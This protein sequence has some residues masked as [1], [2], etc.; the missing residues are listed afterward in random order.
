[1]STPR[2]TL[3]HKHPECPHDGFHNHAISRN[4]WMHIPQKQ[5]SRRFPFLFHE[6]LI[7]RCVVLRRLFVLDD[8]CEVMR[9]ARRINGRPKMSF[10]LGCITAALERASLLSTLCFCEFDFFDLTCCLAFGSYW[11]PRMVSLVF[12]LS[13][14]SRKKTILE[15]SNGM[16]IKFPTNTHGIVLF[17]D[18]RSQINWIYKNILAI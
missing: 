1:M 12:N 10:L 14:I 7:E 8:E 3:D 11:P 18:F 2:Q 6:I 17:G 16:S 9:L 5:L 13:A 4:H 15:I